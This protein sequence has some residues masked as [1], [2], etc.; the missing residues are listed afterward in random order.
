M[1]T[2]RKWGGDL[3]FLLEN[4][5][6]KDFRIRYRNMSLG[7]LWSLINPL[8]MMGVLTFV[9]GYVLGGNNIPAYPLFILCGLIPFNFFTGAV[10]SGTT[11]IVDNA[12]LVKRVTVPREVVPVASVLSNCVHLGIQFCLLV[13]LALFFH[14][15]PTESWLWLPVVWSLYMI[16]V[17]GL[18]LGASA[19]NVFVRDTRYLVE[20]F[21]LVLFWLVP[22]FYTFPDKYI[23]VYRFNPVAALVMAMRNILLDHR[24]PAASLVRNMLIVAVV[25]LALGAW[26]FERL[27][28]HFYEHI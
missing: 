25:T 22:I 10:L 24:A 6:L 20:S 9:F 4:L 12:G 19:I 28:A 2:P 15:P 27:K 14:L 18:A 7:I 17:C 16:F 3:P 26:I 8:V 1:P 5:I 21:N 11:S 23:D 13:A